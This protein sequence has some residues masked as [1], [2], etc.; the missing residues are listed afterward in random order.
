MTRTGADDEKTMRR[1]S[2]LLCRDRGATSRKTVAADFA[3]RPVATPRGTMFTT[4]IDDLKMELI[5]TFTLEQPL[6]IL[7]GLL[8]V[9]SVGQLPP[10]SEAMN[11]RVD[12]K[13]RDAEGLSHDD[14]CRLM[15][16]AGQLFK[17]CKRLRDISFVLIHK[18]VRQSV[19][20]LGFAR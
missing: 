11:M 13:C 10:L 17:F 6:E 18:H 1:R 16:D 2:S 12:R 15:S 3:L 19:D 4:V 7:F 9:A 14:A 8:H 5:P 20:R